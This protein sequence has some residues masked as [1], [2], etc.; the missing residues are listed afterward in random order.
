MQD[1]EI[2]VV[3]DAGVDVRPWLRALGESVQIR[4]LQNL[5]NKSI[6]AA[7][8][9]GIRASR[10]KYIAYLDDDGQFY[11]DHLAVLVEAAESSGLAVVYSN[12][13]QALVSDSE[14]Q[15]VIERSLVYHGIFELPDLLVSN[16]FPMN[17]IVHLRSCLVKIGV[18]DETLG[19]HEDWDLWVRLFHHFQYHHVRQTTCEYRVQGGPASI[20]KIN[21]TTICRTV[22]I[23]HRRY[24]H[25]SPFRSITRE[26]QRKYFRMLASELK[27]ISAPIEPWDEIKLLLRKIYAA[28]RNKNAQKYLS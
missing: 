3:N 13:C 11:P 19:S 10:G 16:Q 17:C 6:S 20:I 8:N 9:L 5:Q 21:G 27:R 15:T 22:K 12:S 14:G 28:V 23:I 4:V 2:I 7:R 25:I 18:F 24:L 26:A 1:F